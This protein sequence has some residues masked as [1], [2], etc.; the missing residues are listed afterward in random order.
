MYPSD[1][2][3]A[4]LA[5]LRS[6]RTDV[7]KGNKSGFRERSPLQKRPRAFT[8]LTFGQ[9]GPYGDGD[10]A[11]GRTQHVHSPRYSEHV[12]AAHKRGHPM[13]LC[14]PLLAADLCLKHLVY[15]SLY[16]QLRN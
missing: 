2:V 13:P 7:D 4:L 3:L 15:A 14:T 6:Q 16:Q 1:P 5:G 9:R 10:A 12:L 8:Q 11:Q